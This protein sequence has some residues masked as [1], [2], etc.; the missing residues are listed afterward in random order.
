MSMVSSSFISG[1]NVNSETSGRCYVLFC[2]T[3]VYTCFHETA[4]G[5]L[6][7]SGSTVVGSI[8]TFWFYFSSIY[9][10]LLYCLKN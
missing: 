4:A 9:L 5:V 10:D 8:V 7:G 2:V 1:S 6:S 3:V